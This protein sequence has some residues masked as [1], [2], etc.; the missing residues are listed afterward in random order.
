MSCG[1]LTYGFDYECDD[2]NGG[3]KQ[4]SLLISQW[5]DITAHTIVSGEVTSITQAGATN[6]YRYQV[7]KEIAGAL[8]TETHDPLLGTTVY[9]SVVDFML[10]KLSASKN[11]QLQ[12]LVSRPVVVIYQD[13]EDTYHVIGISNGAEK[14][15]TNTSQTGKA[16]G[17][18]NGYN[19][20]F[21]SRE[22]TYPPIVQSGVIAGLT[23][24]A[25][26]S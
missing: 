21:T 9:E 13:N 11:V 2:A 23:I 10:N 12:L 5:A 19:L 20:A 14:V 15:G 26:L 24:S 3:I 6:F 7:K 17:D 8:T 18:N 4:G 25:E 22:K 1:A 16:L